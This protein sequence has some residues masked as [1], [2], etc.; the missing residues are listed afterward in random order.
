[1]NCNVH[2][3]LALNNELRRGNNPTKPF[4]TFK[5]NIRGSLKNKNKKIKS[6]F[7]IIYL[8]NIFVL[9]I[10]IISLHNR[11]SLAVI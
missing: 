1:V 11:S 8:H 3:T 6:W 5:E 2:K 10:L 4:S 9:L 7:S